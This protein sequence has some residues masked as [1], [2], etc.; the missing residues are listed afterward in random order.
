MKVIVFGA[1]GS[2]GRLAVDALLKAGHTV[3]AF[4]R[5]P[6]KLKDQK[7]QAYLFFWGCIKS[8]RYT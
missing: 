8:H 3:T 6:E 4:A 2:I 7:H 5:N 1:T